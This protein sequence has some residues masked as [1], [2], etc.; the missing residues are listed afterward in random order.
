MWQINCEPTETKSHSLL[1]LAFVAF[2]WPRQ[3]SPSNKTQTSKCPTICRSNIYK[4]M[5]GRTKSYQDLPAYRALGLVVTALS[6]N[7]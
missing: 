3:A 1:A 4:M 6:Y 5:Y 2:P 7:V